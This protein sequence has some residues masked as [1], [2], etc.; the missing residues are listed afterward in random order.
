VRSRGHK[1]KEE[2]KENK[3]EAALTLVNKSERI[4]YESD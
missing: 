2:E 3:S 4:N 1:K